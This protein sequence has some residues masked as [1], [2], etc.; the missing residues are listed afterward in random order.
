MNVRFPAILLALVVLASS[1]NVSDGQ[2]VWT[3]GVGDWFDPDNWSLDVPHSAS[4]TSFDAIIANGGTAQLQAPGGNV[5]RLRVGASGGDG[6]LLID[7]GTLV[8]TDDLH[9]NEGGF[10][11]SMTVRNGSTVTAPDTVVGFSGGFHSTFTLSGAGTTYNS[12]TSF[13]AAQSSSGVGATVAVNG[14]AVLSSGTTS[15]GTGG[16]FSATVDGPGSRWSTTGAFA[17]GTGGNGTLF[18]TN[19]GTVHVGT[20]LSINSLSNVQLDGGTL[21][22][23]TI[24][25]GIT[26]LSYASGTLQLAGNRDIILDGGLFDFYG[27]PRVIPAGKGLYIEGTTTIRQNQSLSVSGGTFTSQGLL[28]IGVLNSASGSL[29]I[30][31]GGTAVAGAGAIIDQFGFATVNGAGSSLSVAGNLQLA[32]VTRGDLIIQNG[33]SVYVGGAFSIGSSALFTLNGGSLRFNG[34]SRV[35]PTTQFIF[36]AGTIQLAGNRTIGSDAAILDFF[37]AAPNIPAG[38]ALVVEGTAMLTPSAPVTLSGGTLSASTLLMTPGSRLANTVTT[39]APGAMLALAG[40]MIDATGGDLT[41]GDATKVNGFYGAGALQTGQRTVTL[42][43]ANDAVFDS[44][45]LVTLG[46]GGSPGTLAAANGLTL[47]FGGNVTGFGMVDTPD[48]STTPLINNGHISGASMAEPIT[49]AG[50]V[51]G[52]GTLDNV[53]VTGTLAPGFSPATVT[54]GSVAYAGQ[55]EIELGGTALGSFDRLEHTLGA[56]IAQLGG[57]LV[58]SLINGFVPAVGDTFEFLTATG[59]VNGTF[60]AETLP[61][62]AGGLGWNVN[63]GADS[64]VLEVTAAPSFTADFDEDGDVDGDDLV[65]WRGDFGVNNLSDAD[66]DGDSDGDDFLQWQ[67][68]L[69]STSTVPVGTAVPEPTAFTLALLLACLATRNPHPQPFSLREKGAR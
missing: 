61:S 58:V 7:A 1:S 22:F 46:A 31:N 3:A 11:S 16:L 15:L 42:L 2:T 48:S 8:V 13:I 38:K 55:L 24:S 57:S 5:R 4:G 51:K 65:Q 69:G 44:A 14:G 23:N 37:G 68:Q 32:A 27:A 10:S 20:A 47:D 17:V 45:A 56:G 39:Q 64:V 9:V 43:D 62:L 29:N 52:V 49:L 53:D 28:T 67:R 59:G 54:L 6:N 66:S 25:S 40:S 12:T 19:G 35:T 18:I 50:Y 41:L 36:A 34:Y 33:G 26:R 60:A 21:R 30:S 63:Y